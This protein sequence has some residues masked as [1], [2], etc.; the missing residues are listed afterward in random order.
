[1]RGNIIFTYND[2]HNYV[3]RD[4]DGSLSLSPQWYDSIDECHAAMRRYGNPIVDPQLT[5][6]QEACSSE[7]L[8]DEYMKSQYGEAVARHRLLN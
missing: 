6:W 3:V 7:R 4:V 8:V 2:Q 5:Q 1:M